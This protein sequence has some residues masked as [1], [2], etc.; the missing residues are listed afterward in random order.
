LRLDRAGDS[1]GTQDLISFFIA[2]SNTNQ[3]DI[4]ELEVTVEQGN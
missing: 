2:D 4:F 3:P 1:D